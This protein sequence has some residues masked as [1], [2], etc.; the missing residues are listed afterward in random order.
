M[1][2]LHHRFAGNRRE[3]L[4]RAGGGFGALALAGLMAD[5]RKSTFASPSESPRPHFF[6][7][8]RN[9]IF[10]FMDGGP[11]HLDTFDPKPMVNKFAGQPLPSSIKRVLTPMGV[12]EN[13]LLAC[14]RTWKQ[15]GESG[16]P[17][18]DWYP[19]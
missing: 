4:R 8:A 14:K 9:V 15:Y 18:S 10:L 7:A 2:N 16:I 6:G 12:N 5:E 17:V 1:H 11:S 3:F 19:L 13:G